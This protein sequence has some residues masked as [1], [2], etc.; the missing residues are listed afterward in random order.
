MIEKFF[1]WEDRTK[2]WMETHTIKMLFIAV[3]LGVII[4]VGGG[5]ALHAPAR[6]IFLMSGGYSL[7]LAVTQLSVGG[8]E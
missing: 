2:D 6:Q 8:K 1:A 7:I 4:G 3:F 5:L